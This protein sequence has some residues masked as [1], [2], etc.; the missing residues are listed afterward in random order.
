M[1]WKNLSIATV[2][3]FIIIKGSY[4]P[5]SGINLFQISFCDVT[6]SISVCLFFRQKQFSTAISVTK[7]ATLILTEVG[8]ELVHMRHMKPRKCE[9]KENVVYGPF[10]NTSENWCP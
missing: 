3:L 4:H 5:F 9:I 8:L 2:M 1:V 10:K 6:N 7:I